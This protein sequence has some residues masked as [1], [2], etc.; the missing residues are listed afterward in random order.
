MAKT[1]VAYFSASGVTAKVAGNL[2]KA[3]GAD[4]YEIAPE[5]PYTK[6]DLNWMN[7]KSRSSVEMADRSSRP[8]IASKVDNMEQYDL[9][10]VGFPVWWYRE[11]SIIDTFMESY[12]FSGK[13]VVPFATS[14]G[15]GLGDSYKNMQESAPGA[16]VI[17]GKK[18]PPSASE[19]SLKEWAEQFM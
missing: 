19:A 9:V 15:S 5:V 13:T 6:A 11:P 7:K 18:F 12:D 1:L 16:K 4:L 14:G 10:F 2:A 17:D 8:A 3:I